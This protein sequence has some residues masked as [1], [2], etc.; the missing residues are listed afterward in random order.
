VSGDSFH[1]STKID[2]QIDMHG[3][4]A[5]KW[6]SIVTN[7]VSSDEH[8]RSRRSSKRRER[9]GEKRKGGASW[10]EETV[11]WTL[12]SCIFRWPDQH[13]G[14]GR[15]M[16]TR[17]GGCRRRDL[18]TPEITT[19]KPAHVATH[20]RTYVRRR[21]GRPWKNGVKDKPR[22]WQARRGHQP[23]PGSTGPVRLTSWS[24]VGAESS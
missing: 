12:S 2:P 13:R 16:S 11:T 22:H 3:E 8:D 18:F 20:A 10:E 15:C 23:S 4:A 6:C 19:P 21:Q 17:G 9:E 24:G 7:G 5:S 1:P 14:R